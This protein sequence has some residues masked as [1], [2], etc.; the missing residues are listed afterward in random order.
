MA[1]PRR[2]HAAA[3]PLDHHHGLRKLF[4]ASY[5]SVCV[6]DHS[7]AFRAT[8]SSLTPGCSGKLARI[9]YSRTNKIYL[10]IIASYYY[11]IIMEIACVDKNRITNG[12]DKPRC[13]EDFASEFSDRREDV[14]CVAKL[15]SLSAKRSGLAL[16]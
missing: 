11:Y 4:D 6:V 13:C 9:Q 3:I 16:S 1:Q 15:H 2:N 5:H 8:L 7:L 14:E 12:V 10:Y